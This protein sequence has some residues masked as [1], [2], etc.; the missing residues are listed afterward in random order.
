V[1]GCAQEKEEHIKRQRWPISRETETELCVFG[2]I[3][4]ASFDCGFER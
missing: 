1:C 2:A 4:R 3:Q